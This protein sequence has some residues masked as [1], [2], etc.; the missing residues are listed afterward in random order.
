MSV[1]IFVGPTLSIPEVQASIKARCLPP[2]GQGDVIRA[3]RDHRPQAIGIIDGFFGGAPAVW[4]KEILWAMAEGVAVFGAASMGALRAAELH[5]FGMQGVG[6]IFEDYR[7]GVLEDDDDVAV[8]HAP[9]EMGYLALSEPMVNIRA[10]LARAE[11]E[12]VLQPA[13]RSALETRAKALHFPERSWPALLEGEA[14]PEAGVADMA[15]LQAWLPAGRVDIKRTDA[16]AMLAAM[17]RPPAAGRP[18]DPPRFHLAT[19]HFLAALEARPNVPDL[20]G[21]E[22][23]TADLVLDEFRLG[24]RSTFDA[25]TAR[26]LLGFASDRAFGERRG[27][28]SDDANA[29]KVDAIR[30][31]NGLFSRSSLEAWLVAND[32]E[33][34]ALLDLAAGAVRVDRIAAL[35]RHSLAAHLIDALRLSGDYPRLAERARRKAA[36]LAAEGPRASAGLPSPERLALRLWFSARLGLVED[37]GLEAILAAS[38][39]P[40]APSLDRVLHRE[41][42]YL[43][44][45]GPDLED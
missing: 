39:F 19:T 38:G 16:L 45:R 17:V 9:A 41:R 1:C 7:D 4:H 42:L 37:A 44:L 2:V 15:R 13:T 40:D 27:P 8:V 26:A 29:S 32:L 31:T 34:G 23:T 22:E 5:G 24:D 33:P 43:T 11:R 3:V 6:R 28:A 10:T 36:R 20:R 25:I 14:G 35:A 21:A 30:T 12:G 18:A